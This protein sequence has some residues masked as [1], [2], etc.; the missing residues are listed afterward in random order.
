MPSL[1]PP[2][3]IR[4]GCWRN[5]TP[6]LP[7]SPEPISQGQ[8]KL[9]LQ[10]PNWKAYRWMMVVSSCWL[11]SWKAQAGTGEQVNRYLSKGKTTCL[12]V[13]QMSWRMPLVRELPFCFS[14]GRSECLFW[15][16][17]GH[18]EPFWKHFQ[19]HLNEAETHLT[20]FN[21]HVLIQIMCVFLHTQRNCLE[22]FSKE[23]PGMF[24]LHISHEFIWWLRGNQ[25]WL[26]CEADW[27][28]C[29]RQ[30]VGGGTQIW[31]LG[32]SPPPSITLIWKGRREQSG[33]GE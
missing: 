11:C 2:S 30:Q 15:S 9:S 20:D 24:R 26:I 29:V 25:G 13:Q 8:H 7:K 3:T 19:L 23:V 32:P 4:K 5:H 27:N 22:L 12:S 14:L 6:A 1:F 31:D 17:W 21:A 10:L 16:P 33:R 18:I 28:S